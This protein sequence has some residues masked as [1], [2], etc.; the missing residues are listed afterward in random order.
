MQ[1]EDHIWYIHPNNTIYISCYNNPAYILASSGYKR[2][3]SSRWVENNLSLTFL[4]CF[5]HIL[6]KTEQNVF[7]LLYTGYIE[8]IYFKVWI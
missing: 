3:S 8:E 5:K 4:F 1:K 2:Q 7:S 6:Y